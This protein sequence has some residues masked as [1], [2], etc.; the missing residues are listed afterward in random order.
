MAMNWHTFRVRALSALFFVAIML[1]GLLWNEWSFFIL[2]SIVHAGCWIEYQKLIKQIDARTQKVGFWGLIG[3]ILI[4]WGIMIHL[5]SSIDFGIT[6]PLQVI[7]NMTLALGILFLLMNEL[8]NYRQFYLKN[9][10]YVLLGL[11]YLSLS[12]GLLLHIRSAAIWLPEG[13]TEGLSE[14]TSSL[15]KL[16]GYFMPLIIIGS[17]WVND[18]M[19]YIVGSLVG[20]TP[21]SKL[22]PKKT[23]EGAVGG[24]VLSVCL[25]WLIGEFLMH[26]SGA[27]WAMIAAV[28]AVAG[29]FGDLFESKL[30]R[31]AGVK[32]SGAILPGHG[33][34]LDRFDSL[35]FATPAIWICLRF[36]P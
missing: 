12:F 26:A 16:E 3:S 27:K 5:S 9:F 33:G 22:S 4:G 19:A 8:Y 21:F 28:V 1:V 10:F 20:K 24:I 31:M 34:F 6:F 29:V 13:N 17:I 25:A 35:L 11:L 23:W 36:F 15:A 14:V 2:F 32:D 7:A 18:T 30:K